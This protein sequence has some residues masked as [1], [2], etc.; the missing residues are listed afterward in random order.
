MGDLL[1]VICENHRW[2]NVVGPEALSPVGCHVLILPAGLSCLFLADKASADGIVWFHVVFSVPE[3][4]QSQLGLAMTCFKRIKS[5]LIGTSAT[6]FCMF[7]FVLFS[8]QEL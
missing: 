2:C 6:L 8:Q 1:F 7:N 3:M 4:I 5:G